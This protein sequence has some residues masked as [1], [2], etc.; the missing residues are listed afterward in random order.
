MLVLQFVEGLTDRQAAEAVR[1][2]IDVKYALVLGLEDPG[3]N[4][5]VLSELRD[6]LI[7]A[8]AGRQ[9]L[10]GILVAAWDKGLLKAA[11]RARTDSTHVLSSARGLYW[12]EMVTEP[13]PICACS[14][15][16]GFSTKRTVSTR[17]FTCLS[18][19]RPSTCPAL[20]CASPP[21]SCGSTA[22]TSTHA[23]GV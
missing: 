4:H 22:A 14:L 19:R 5:S 13:F 21:S 7:Q 17:G 20:P 1:A 2:R 15:E 18:T 16:D 11:G 8:D 10:D 23:G 9:I 3:F 12:L 6:R